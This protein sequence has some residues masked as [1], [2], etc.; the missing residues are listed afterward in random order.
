MQNPINTPS[1]LYAIGDI[2]GRLDLLERAIEA[3]GR[4]VERHGP[5]ALTVTVGDYIDRG[6]DSRGVIERLAANPFPTSYVA[7]KGNHESFLELFLADSTTGLHWRVQGGD[8]TLFSYGVDLHLSDEEAAE[9]LRAA[10]PPAHVRF[11]QALKMS[12]TVGKY[13]FCHAGVRPGVPLERQDDQ[14]L[15]WIRGDFLN[16]TADFGKIVVH[17]HTPVAEPQ[18]LA[19]RINID[20]GAFATGRLTCVALDDHG[21]RFLQ[22]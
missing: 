15:L 5:A 4:D 22:V 11:L 13:F 1:R 21:H 16:S 2:H 19:N 8:E 10:L 9:R 7:L 18:V 6:P 20:T 12:H 17:G 14:D 3:I